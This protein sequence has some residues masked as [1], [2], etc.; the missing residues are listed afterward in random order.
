M[1]GDTQANWQ[2]ALPNTGATRA[3][4]ALKFS[5]TAASTPSAARSATT[6]ALSSPGTQSGG[7]SGTRRLRERGSPAS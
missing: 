5:T 7:A 4:T 2:H 6:P 3:I 1:S